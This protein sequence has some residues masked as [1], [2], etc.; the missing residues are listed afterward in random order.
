MSN[1]A[2]LE[3]LCS[4]HGPSGNEGA[5]TEFLLAY[6]KANRESWAVK[7][8]IISGDGFQDCMIWIFGKPKTAIYAH[9]DTVGFTVGYDN[10]LIPIGSPSAR[11]GDLLSGFDK[12]IEVIAPYLEEHECITAPFTL[13]R[14]TTLTYAPDF[15]VDD[16]FIISPYLDNRL[17]V[18]NALQQAQ[19]MQNGAIVFGTYEEHR[20]G[21]VGYLAE[22]LFN[23][24]QVKQ[25]LIS[26]ITWVTEGVLAGA[27]VAISLRDSF[28]PRKS[29]LDKILAIAAETDIP[30]QLEV[31]SAGG[32][33]GSEIQRSPIPVDWCF[34][35][36]P[37]LYAHTCKEKVHLADI[38]ATVQLYK[39]LME[40]L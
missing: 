20:G 13:T 39:V 1:W 11:T 8:T 40:K 28:V 30:Y 33:D 27:G 29:Y 19:W 21:M 24:Y 37:E 6:E 4:I 38:D 31:E 32:S 12:D 18:W 22:Y 14:G 35:G 5:M 17:G 2:L 3:Q 34:I 9:I 16:N 15:S 23:N 7:P 25:A 10:H 36:A 26:D